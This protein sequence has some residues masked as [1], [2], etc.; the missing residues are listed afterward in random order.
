MDINTVLLYN[1]YLERQ[2]SQLELET[3]AEK[4]DEV[5]ERLQN[6]SQQR[7]ATDAWC[8][9]V[10]EATGETIEYMNLCLQ[11]CAP[12]GDGRTLTVPEVVSVVVELCELRHAIAAVDRRDARVDELLDAVGEAIRDAGGAV[13]IQD[14]KYWLYISRLFDLDPDGAMASDLAADLSRIAVGGQIEYPEDGGEP[15]AEL[16]LAQQALRVLRVAMEQP[17]G[18]LSTSWVQRRFSCGYGRAARLL[19]WLEEQGYVQSHA[20]MV[21]EGLRGRR[22]YVTRDTL[23]GQ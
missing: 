19:D 8:D 10:A 15:G 4:A 16:T 13:K 17:E 12:L 6:L 5:C 22:I 7:Q 9:A 14:E 11:L 21:A 18:T 1:K 20:D 23:Q 2:A 3:V